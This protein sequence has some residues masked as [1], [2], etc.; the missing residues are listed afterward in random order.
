MKGHLAK[1]LSAA[2]LASLACTAQANNII[3]FEGFAKGTIIDDEYSDIGVSIYGYNK[4]QSAGNLG[5]IFD[6]TETNTA[7]P[8][9]EAPF[10]NTDGSN[11]GV[12]NPG[13]VLIIHEHPG[14]CDAYTCGDDPDDEG[15]KPAGYFNIVFDEAVALNSIDFFDIEYGENGNTNKNKITLTGTET[16]GQF[17]TPAT[18]GDNQWTRLN[19]NVV[20]VTSIKIKLHGSGAIDNIN[21]ARMTVPAPATAL[22]AFLGMFLI[23]SRRRPAPASTAA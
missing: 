13:N 9:L 11:L 10:Y 21:F 23:V 12:A 18:G 20:G 1:L 14:E 19:F 3:D 4:D 17:H 5:V 15:S 6:T 7:D 8:D 22:L 2:L 16:Y